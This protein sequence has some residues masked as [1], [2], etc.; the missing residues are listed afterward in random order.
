MKIKLLSFIALLVL[1]L[2]S[3]TFAS[4]APSTDKAAN[5]N[6]TQKQTAANIAFVTVSSNFGVVLNVTQTNTVSKS[7]NDRTAAG[8]KFSGQ[9]DRQYIERAGNYVESPP[10]DNYTNSTPT[11]H[12]QPN[13][14]TFDLFDY[15][16]FVKRE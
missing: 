14:R 16:S 7:F 2:S 11:L 4:A 13:K 5:S 12:H 3:F 1:A 15:S 6:I 10:N 9:N 8:Q